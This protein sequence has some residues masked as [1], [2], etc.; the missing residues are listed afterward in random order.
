M[1]GR[2]D[3]N[4]LLRGRMK[5]VDQLSVVSYSSYHYICFTVSLMGNSINN[6][7]NLGMNFLMNFISFPAHPKSKHEVFMFTNPC[8]CLWQMLMKIGPCRYKIYQVE[9]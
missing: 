8:H 7:F 6:S 4:K 5:T 1:L 2:G 3:Q 9:C